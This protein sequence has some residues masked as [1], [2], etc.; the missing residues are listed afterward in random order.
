M[1]FL[2]DLVTP[3]ATATTMNA[4]TRI[5]VDG[6]FRIGGTTGSRLRDI[7]WSSV[8]VSGVNQDGTTVVTVTLS[9]A[10]PDTTYNVFLAPS[11]VNSFLFSALVDNKT[12]TSFQIR[13][14]KRGAAGNSVVQVDWIIID[15]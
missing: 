3:T 2:G 13:V 1:V 15:F 12:T 5:N 10:M 6:N 9:P 7:R 4:S 8:S 11:V 14:R